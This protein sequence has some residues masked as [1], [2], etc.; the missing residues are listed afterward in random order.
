M[1][2]FKFKKTSIKGESVYEKDCLYLQD[3]QKIES[4][5]NFFS[6]FNNKSFLITGAS[7]LI[8]S[9][10]VDFLMYL[11]HT[12]LECNIKI[13]A[14]FS[15]EK[16]MISR[17]NSYISDELF[18]PIYADLS[19]SFDF[20]VD[21]DFVIHLAAITHPKAYVDSPIET[22]LLN[23][24]GL[25]SVL[26]YLKN[27]NVKKFIFSSSFEVYG[28]G[29]SY[30]IKEESIGNLD[31]LQRRSSYAQ[32]KRLSENMCVNFNF[33]YK[34]IASI[35]R[36]GYVY[37]PTSKLSSSKAD[38]EFLRES[39]VGNDIILRSK[40][41]QKRSYCYVFDAVSAILH[42]LISDSEFSIFNVSVNDSNITLFEFTKKMAEVANV[43]ICFDDNNANNLLKEN[44]DSI[45]DNTKLLNTGWH[46]IF[47]IDDGIRNTFLIKKNLEDL[48]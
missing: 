23:I 47:K 38:I 11:N 29:V 42:L 19:S 21:V 22:S 27:S 7:G 18:V 40:G 43:N 28:N 8:G 35:L 24:N 26:N 16:S 10:L 9:A 6:K 5:F 41:E 1:N 2:C 30:P 48:N 34:N 46:P 39:L 45:L 13:Y 15:S 31:F 17:F 32:S 3:M 33:V 14:V 4:N 20:D 12:F 37:G 36:F 44:C 25:A